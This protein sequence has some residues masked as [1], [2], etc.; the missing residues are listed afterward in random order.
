MYY[1]FDFTQELCPIVLTSSRSNMHFTF[2]FAHELCTIVFTSS[3]SKCTI[4]TVT[5]FST[6]PTLT[7]TW[8]KGF[9]LGLLKNCGNIHRSLTSAGH[10]DLLLPRRLVTG[11]RVSTSSRVSSA[12]HSTVVSKVGFHH[13]LEEVDA[14]PTENAHL[15]RS[16]L[17]YSQADCS[18][19]RA[20]GGGP[21][22]AHSGADCVLDSSCSPVAEVPRS[23]GQFCRSGPEL[24]SAGLGATLIKE[25]YNLSEITMCI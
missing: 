19:G 1:S 18:S 3:W 21:S 8:P 6:R 23:S 2:D 14:H 16:L 24:Q 13:Q 10:K 5:S 22:N 11:C 17:R 9:P 12:N 4:Y 15:S 25:H 7:Y 20:Q